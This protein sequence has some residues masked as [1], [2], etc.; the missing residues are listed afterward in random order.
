MSGPHFASAAQEDLGA[1]PHEATL[2]RSPVAPPL[3]GGDLTST[4]INVSEIIS[5][6]YEHIVLQICSNVFTVIGSE[7]GKTIPPYCA[8]VA[9]RQTFFQPS[10]FQPLA[11]RVCTVP[12]SPRRAPFT[13]KIVSRQGTMCYEML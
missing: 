7:N 5:K 2:R 10:Q 4:K 11:M 13:G 3:R 12:G 8:V 9:L 6:V 1:G